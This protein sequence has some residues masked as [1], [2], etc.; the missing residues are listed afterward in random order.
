MPFLTSKLPLT[1]TLV[2]NLFK[3]CTLNWDAN[4][5]GVTIGDMAYEASAVLR[6]VA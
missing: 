5:V 1:P 3:L 4:G 6:D 2:Q